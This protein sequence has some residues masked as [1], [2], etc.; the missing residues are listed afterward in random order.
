MMQCLFLEA[1]CIHMD[2]KNVTR[3]S[4]HGFTMGK[5]YLAGLIAFY[6]EAT[7]R[8]DE[9]RAV[10]IFYRNF[11]TFDTV[12]HNILTGKLQKCGLDSKT[13]NE[14]MIPIRLG[15]EHLPFEESLQ[16]LGLFSLE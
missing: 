11:I 14:Q 2:Y 3:S 5:S 4:Q 9:R 6:D 13:G 8:M 15:L 10:D 16:E 12:S 1:I 7:T